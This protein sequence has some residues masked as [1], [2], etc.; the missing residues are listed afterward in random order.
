MK[1]TH[2][3]THTHPTWQASMQ[4]TTFTNSSV[5][6]FP[7]C[8]EKDEPNISQSREGQKYGAGRLYSRLCIYDLIWGQIY[9]LLS[10]D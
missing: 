5:F 3:H 6:L 10:S 9:C 4:G 7:K 8:P 1:L 2:T